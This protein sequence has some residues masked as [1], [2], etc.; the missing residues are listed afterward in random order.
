MD[1]RDF[2]GGSL[3]AFVAAGTLA[4]GETAEGTQDMPSPV[5]PRHTKLAVR[6]VMTNMIHTAAWEGPCRWKAVSPAQEAASAEV[7]FARWPKQIAARFGTMS[8]IR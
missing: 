2:L 6:P 5:S 7:R 1:R 3:G 8:T 4:V